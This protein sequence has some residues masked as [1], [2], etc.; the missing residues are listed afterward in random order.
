M[1]TERGQLYGPVDVIH[2][3]IA[4]IAT[5]LLNKSISTY[6]VAMI[7]VATKLARMKN[8][9]NHQDSYIDAINY[10]SFAAEFS[11]N[12]DTILVAMEDELVKMT[13]DVL[14]EP[15]DV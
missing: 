4:K 14:K 5:L 13:R 10:L 15:S 3:D 12:T 6:D 7:H 1:L 8:Q 9:R 2:D 11:N